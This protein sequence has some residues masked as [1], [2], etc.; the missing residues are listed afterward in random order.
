MV[1]PETPG[2]YIHRACVDA[3]VGERNTDNNCHSAFA[4]EVLVPISIGDLDV[5]IPAG[6]P[7]K[8]GVCVRDHS[9]ID[10]DVVRVSVNGT[11]LFTYV[12]FADWFCR[13]ATVREGANLIE[14]YAV[15][16]T[17][18]IGGCPNNINTG[19]LEARAS[20]VARTFWLV[21]AGYTSSANLNVELGDPGTCP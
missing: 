1:V 21:P 11:E 9:C 14:A 13:T 15:N 4:I 6:C 3:V 5:T 16:G 8:V 10:G 18:Y 17:G 20:N 12:M 2:F 19:Q 7:L